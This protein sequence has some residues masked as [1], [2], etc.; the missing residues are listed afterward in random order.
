[1]YFNIE[2]RRYT[3]S[4]SKLSEWI[5]D[6]IIKN[7]NGNVFFDIFA[8]TGIIA[9]TALEYYDH[10][11]INDHLYSNNIIYKA[12]FEQGEWNKEKVNYIIEEYNNIN[13]NNLSD[14]YFSINFGN[15]YF[16]INNSKKIGFIRE[17]L[18]DKKTILS[19]KEY[20]ILLASLVY[21]IDRIANTVGHY[22]AYI[23]KPIKERQFVINLIKPFICKRV[24]IF[25]E[26]ANLLAKKIVS[27]ITYIDP[28][29]NSRQYS[30]FYHLLETLIKWDKPN[31]YGVAMKPPT[32]NSSDYCKTNAPES[33]NDLV[34][35]L[36]CKY[37]AVSYNNTYFSKSNSS[38]NKIK[39]EQ[40]KNIL[41]KK[42]KTKIYK[43]NHKFFNSGKT[44]F[45]NHQEYLFITKVNNFEN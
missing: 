4:K 18:E 5:I 20:N 7:C 15:K 40:I 26:D 38:K 13:P 10:I 35:N 14:N 19:C 32:E 31:L 33:L 30:R 44:N 42:G 11:I 2:N 6:L 23:K 45:E 21:S 36:K 16:S 39:L 8:G 43:K 29:Y 9:A 24:D 34:N 41:E 1:M 25:Q 17:D 37:I 22:D 12:F 3:G 27:D 28:P